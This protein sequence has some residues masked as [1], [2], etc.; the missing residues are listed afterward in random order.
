MNETIYIIR[1]SN[2]TIQAMLIFILHNFLGIVILYL[3]L[4]FFV[5]FIFFY[6]LH[7]R[8]INKVLA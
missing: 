1:T 7:Y 4:E 2:Q 3:S 5:C 8:L 6:S